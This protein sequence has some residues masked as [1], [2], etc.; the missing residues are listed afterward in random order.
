MRKS[1]SLILP[2]EIQEFILHTFNK[3]GNRS[4]RTGCSSFIHDLTKEVNTFIDDHSQQLP[5]LKTKF[6]NGVSE[7]HVLRAFNLKGPHGATCAL[8]DALAYYST[9]GQC[10]WNGLIETFFPQH[11]S[12]LDKKEDQEI[13]LPQN[14]TI[15]DV[16][17]MQLQII[18]MLQKR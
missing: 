17:Q 11:N 5:L 14:I 9:G 16:Y 8:R 3:N 13:T 12:L 4:N 2:N 1:T 10:N 6:Y 18:Q 15:A 7:S